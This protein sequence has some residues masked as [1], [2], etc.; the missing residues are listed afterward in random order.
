[1]LDFVKFKA[2]G[3]TMLEWKSLCANPEVNRDKRGRIFY[4]N[5]LL[6]YYPNVKE[7][8]VQNSLHKFY[9]KALNNDL[10]VALNHNDFS[11]TDLTL[12]VEEI[13]Q[14]LGRAAIDLKLFSRFEYGV[15]IDIGK[16]S[17]MDFINTCISMGDTQN[18]FFSIAKQGGREFGKHT[19]FFGRKE[20]LY[21]KGRQMSQYIYE[22]FKL[23]ENIL[24][25]E[26]V[27]FGKGKIKTTLGLNQDPTLEDT[28]K[29]AF[30][31]EIGKDLIS[32]FKRIKPVP[33]YDGKT[34]Q[35]ILEYLGHAH[36]VIVKYDKSILTQY[37]YN[38]HRKAGRLLIEQYRDDDDS[39]HNRISKQ[40][41]KKIN[42][43]TD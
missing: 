6:K 12:T 33:V 39:T 16:E 1:M 19:N 34:R 40:L 28:T 14:T 29:K 38:Q 24:R 15:N 43:L 17:P 7:L 31:S 2:L 35:E 27:L 11:R 21:D 13:S 42:A 20:K 25:Y 23:E 9:N 30:Y 4:H 41:K 3:F 18:E 36:P 10:G 37:R 8:W 32:S 5:L 22:P 26:V